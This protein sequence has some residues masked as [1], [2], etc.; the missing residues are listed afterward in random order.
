MGKTEATP[1]LTDPKSGTEPGLAPEVRS[2]A[3]KLLTWSSLIIAVL[4]S[5]CTAVLAVSGIRVLIGLTALA[6]MR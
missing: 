3:T 6:A 2:A 1:V 4:Q 5:L